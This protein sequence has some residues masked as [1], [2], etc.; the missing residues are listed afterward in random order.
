MSQWESFSFKGS[1]FRFFW[2]F[3]ILNFML[4]AW[5]MISSQLL[6]SSSFAFWAAMA[7][8]ATDAPGTVCDWRNEILDAFVVTMFALPLLMMGLLGGIGGGTRA[9]FAA[10][11][12]LFFT[13]GW[14]GWFDDCCTLWALII[15]ATFDPAVI[16]LELSCLKAWPGDI[17][18]AIPVAIT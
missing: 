4:N 15:V 2:L 5:L 1:L 16:A 10:P 12:W 13:G 7:W 3:F 6:Y 11:N 9:L 14:G 8:A 18:L 17:D